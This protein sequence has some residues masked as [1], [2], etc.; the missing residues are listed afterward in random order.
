MH[1]F[2]TYDIFL[3]ING[4]LT[5]YCQRESGSSHGCLV[6]RG[7]SRSGLS[8]ICIWCLVSEGALSFMMLV[9]F[10]SGED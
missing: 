1:N 3:G 8:V 5:W 6:N 2:V 9:C 10:I 4:F 7:F